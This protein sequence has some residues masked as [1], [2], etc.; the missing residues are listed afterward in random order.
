MSVA[1]LDLNWTRE[2][3]CLGCRIDDR[4]I[5]FLFLAG[6]GIFHQSVQTIF[7]VHSVSYRRGTQVKRWE[8]VSSK[9]SRSSGWCFL[10]SG[11][12]HGVWLRLADDD[13]SELFVG[14][15]LKGHLHCL[16]LSLQLTFENLMD[17]EFR[18]VVLGQLKPH[19][20]GRPEN[21]DIELG[22]VQ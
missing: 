19:T 20:V 9:L 4:G 16:S 13:V 15:I 10:V 8:I 3:F 2:F 22:N 18:N 6:K 12:S 14:S 1:V 5:D 11:F 17:R 7:G 21:Q